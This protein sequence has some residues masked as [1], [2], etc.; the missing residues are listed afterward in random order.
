MATTLHLVTQR[1]QP[2]GS[3][4]RCCERCGLA[5]PA[6]GDREA[7]ARFG[8][9]TPDEEVYRDPPS[10]YVACVTLGAAP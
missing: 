2:Y 7:I 10:H 8:A 5:V 6:F 4:R 3:V 9:H 1:Y